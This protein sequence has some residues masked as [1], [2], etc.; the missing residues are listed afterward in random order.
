[1]NEEALQLLHDCK[2][3]QILSTDEMGW[4]YWNI[5]DIPAVQRKPQEVYENHVEFVK[6]GKQALFPHKLHWIVSDAT[7]ALTLS[8]GDYF[9][10]WKTWYLFACEHSTR[11][12][13]N[14]GVRFESH[15][16]AAQ[17]LLVLERFTE[18]EVPLKNMLGVINEDEKWGNNIFAGLTYYT[19]L[20]EQA[21]NL[22][23]T[24]IFKEAE[25][26]IKNLTDRVKEVIQ[27]V[28]D[29][30]DKSMLGSWESFNSSRLT[31]NSMTV[32][33]HNG[34][35]T[36]HKIGRYEESAETFQLALQNGVNITTYG[37]A[38]LLSSLWKANKNNTEVLEAFAKYSP[39]G[40][41]VNELI[42][43]DSDLT[44]I[45]W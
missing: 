41:S 5:S 8:L 39:E 42:K 6:W 4:M 26:N 30:K 14:R 20:A 28:P 33:L 27:T 18:L 21:F 17:S 40:L 2:R 36:F 1:M 38:L 15:R 37:L 23:Q 10:E 12:E 45:E 44:D 29:E 11:T 25:K 13:E 31:K 35:C 32:L 7:Q 43:F 3:T 22:N 34:A 24:E 9:D 16:A 19:L